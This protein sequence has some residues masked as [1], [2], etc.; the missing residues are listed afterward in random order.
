MLRNER[1]NRTLDRRDEEVGLAL[2]DHG[3][4]C[5]ELEHLG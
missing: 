2:N 5:T 1:S 4:L 3:M